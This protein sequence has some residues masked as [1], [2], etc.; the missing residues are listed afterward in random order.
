MSKWTIT[1]RGQGPQSNNSLISILSIRIR[2]RRCCL[3]RSTTSALSIRSRLSLLPLETRLF[4]RTNFRKHRV[5]SAKMLNLGMCKDQRQESSVSA[6]HPIMHRIKAKSILTRHQLMPAI[7]VL[8]R[9]RI[10]AFKTSKFKAMIV[11][12]ILQARG[13]TLRTRE[14][15][16]ESATFLLL[17]NRA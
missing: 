12:E 2:T 3:L 5:K 17:V 14:V 6:L 1:V 11:L 4:Q 8:K 9:A 7:T 13:A 15:A 16:K 10:K